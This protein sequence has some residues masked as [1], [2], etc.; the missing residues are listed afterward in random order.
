[1]CELR[2]CIC[3][4]VYDCMSVCVF[5]VCMCVSM[6]LYVAYVYFCVHEHVFVCVVYMCALYIAYVRLCVCAL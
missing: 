5:I 3:A 4:Y 1:M 2:V 6:C